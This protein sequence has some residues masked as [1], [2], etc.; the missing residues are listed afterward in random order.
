[1]LTAKKSRFG[2]SMYS[3][4]GRSDKASRRAAGTVR[5][6]YPFNNGWIVICGNSSESIS[7]PP[8]AFTITSQLREAVSYPTFSSKDFSRSSGVASNARFRRFSNFSLFMIADSFPESFR[9]CNHMIWVS[10]HPNLDYTDCSV[11]SYYCICA[12]CRKYILSK[13]I[14]KEMYSLQPLNLAGKL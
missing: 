7:K 10:K 5:I 1:M 3:I 12:K 6:P 13:I 8:E 14:L 2:F 4:S 9:N 11:L